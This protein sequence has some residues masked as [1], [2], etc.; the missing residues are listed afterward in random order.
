MVNQYLERNKDKGHL[1]FI[2]LF[3]K[4]FYKTTEIC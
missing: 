4:N 3:A 2:T 1:V